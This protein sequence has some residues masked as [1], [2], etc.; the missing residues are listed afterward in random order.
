[1]ICAIVLL[2][3]AP[4]DYTPVMQRA[5]SFAPGVTNMTVS[6]QLIMDSTA[7]G[8]EQFVAILSNPSANANLGNRMATVQIRGI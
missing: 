4:G 2:F 1:M 3:A 5:L 8:L 7:E 6:V